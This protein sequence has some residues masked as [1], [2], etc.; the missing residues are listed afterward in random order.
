M[1]SEYIKNLMILIKEIIRNILVVLHR[2][3]REKSDT[4]GLPPWGDEGFLHTCP[5]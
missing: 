4:Q 3:K 1:P 5:S 2:F